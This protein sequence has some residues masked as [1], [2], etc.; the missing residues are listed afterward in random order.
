M[1]TDEKYMAVA[2]RLAEKGAGFV[3]PNPKVGAVV[4]KDNVVIGEGYHAYFGGPHAEVNAIQMAGKYAK[5]A[6][7]FVTLEPCNH[8]GKTPP[9]SE[10]VLASGICRVVVGI[11]DPNP[12]VASNGIGYLERHGIKVEC[13]VLESRIRKQNEIFLK[14]ITSGRPFCILK[15]A[16]TLDGKTATV[17]GESRWISGAKSREKVHR[18]RNDIAAVMVGADT[19]IKDDP[20][21]TVR[22]KGKHF[23]NPLKVIT[24]ASGRIPMTAKVLASEPQLCIL[25]TTTNTGA[26]RIRNIERLGA[27]VLVCPEKEGHADLDYLMQALGAMGIDSLM[28][29]SGGTLAFAALEANIVDKVVSFIAPKIVGG[30]TAP[31]MIGGKGIEVLSDAVRLDRMT[32]KRSGEDLM[33]EGYVRKA[34]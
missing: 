32:W 1:T 9:C 16:M 7:L 8:H 24:D 15:T 13:G 34:E 20:L 17:S 18:M 10:F 3:N 21:L 29:E 12:D 5:G 28:V 30:I 2:V 33:V 19:V 23:K 6:T 14:Y 22:L 25:A 26:E 27:Q 11:R 31:T 4:V